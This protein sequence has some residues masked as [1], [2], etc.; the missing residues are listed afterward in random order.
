MDELPLLVL[1][2][3]AVDVMAR[4]GNTLTVL[5]NGFIQALILGPLLGL[6]QATALR[7]LTNR[8]AW[9]FAANVTTYL[10]AA[11]LHQL[12]LSFHQQLSLPAWTAPYFPVLAFAIHGAWMLWVT[13]PQAIRTSSTASAP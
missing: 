13:A 12:D 5:R 7:P 9:W 8:W 2:P 3:A 4:G 6:S 10:S 11:L 1:A